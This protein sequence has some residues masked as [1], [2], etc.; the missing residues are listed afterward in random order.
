MRV[1]VV[2]DNDDIREVLELILRMSGHAADGVED[3]ERALAR[4]REATFDL[5]LLDLLMPGMGGLEFLEVYRALYPGTGVPVILTTAAP[6]R[7][8]VPPTCRVDAVLPRPFEVGELLVLIERIAGP[9]PA[10]PVHAGR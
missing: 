2:D 8:A 5:I 10:E 1:L 3:G 4:L 6:V 9:S 7:F